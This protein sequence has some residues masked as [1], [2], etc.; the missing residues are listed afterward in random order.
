[1]ALSMTWECAL[2]VLLVEALAQNTGRVSCI[3]SK[4]A[5]RGAIVQISKK[6]TLIRLMEVQI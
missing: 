1:M 4:G 3:G 2:A 6:S 5:K